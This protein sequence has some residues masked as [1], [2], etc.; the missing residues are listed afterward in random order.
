M[1][2]MF[3]FFAVQMTC[4][5]RFRNNFVADFAEIMDLRV[6][7]SFGT[8]PFLAILNNRDQWLDNA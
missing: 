7:F 2:A 5:T 6:L 3:V 4:P 1:H 8:E